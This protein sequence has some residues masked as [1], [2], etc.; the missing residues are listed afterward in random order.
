MLLFICCVVK[1]MIMFFNTP[2]F[3]C[4]RYNIVANYLTS[5]SLIC[6]IGVI[7]TLSE[8]HLHYKQH[9]AWYTV[10]PIQ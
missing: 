5:P 2:G 9:N 1:R 10:K 4:Q 6:K 3:V 8:V 7:K